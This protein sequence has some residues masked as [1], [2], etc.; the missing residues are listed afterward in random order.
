MATFIALVRSDG[1]YGYTASFPDF[2]ECMV[3]SL[4]LDHVIAKA[5]EALSVHI[6]RLLDANQTIC[7]PTAVDAIE[8]G[9]AL[10]LAAVDVPDDRR[11]VHIDVAIPALSLARID[12]F[13]QRHGLSRAGLFVQAVSRWAGQETEPRE[14]RAGMSDAPT[15]FDFGNP[16]ELRVETIAPHVEGEARTDELDARR[17][18]DI[19]SNS[20]DI[21]AELVR[22]FEE[23]PEPEPIDRAIEDA[24]KSSIR[25][26]E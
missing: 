24:R 19:R 22:L 18:V 11:I 10:L 9:D 2:P 7:N 4:T 3:H 26:A 1:G 6:E 14:R 13:A 12:S 25:E 5:R 8:R 20:D 23:R 16:L 17:E 21:T 15:L